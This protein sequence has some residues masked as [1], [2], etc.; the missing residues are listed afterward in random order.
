MPAIYA[1]DRFGREV[2]ALLDGDVKQVIEQHYRQF[3]IGLQGPDIFFFYGAHTN[4]RVVRFGQHLHK[5]SAFPFFRHARTV[6]RETGRDSREYAYLLGFLCHF[7]LDSECHPYVEEMI[8][9]TGVQH[10]EIEEEFEKLL[11]REDGRDPVAWPVATLVPADEETVQAIQPFYAIRKEE[12]LRERVQDTLHGGIKRA[13]RESHSRISAESGVCG[14]NYGDAR[15]CG[16]D[17][18][19]GHT[20]SCGGESGDDRA[21]SCRCHSGDGRADSCRCHSSSGCA[22]SCRCHSSSG[23]ADS[24]RCHSSRSAAKGCGQ[25]YIPLSVIRSSLRSMKAIKKF[26]TAPQPWK[27]DFIN[28]VFRV[29][30]TYAAMCGVMNQRTDNPKCE[31]T[32]QGLKLRFNEAVELAVQMVCEY[33]LAVRTGCELNKRLDRT[34]S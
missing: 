31:K 23:C 24:C 27:Q 33:D 15:N 11:L 9:E 1:H 3:Q 22:D 12:S 20:D 8:K 19:R 29:T 34:F 6:V 30:G 14:E 32:N 2:C 21:D 18:N 7:I 13:A 10:L 28:G 17:S 4:N 25:D 16:R 26:L 5:V